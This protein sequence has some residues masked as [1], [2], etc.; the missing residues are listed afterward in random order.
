MID[1]DKSKRPNVT[2]GVIILKDGKFL[3]GKR[4]NAVGAG[5]W[6]LPGGKLE[7]GE[8][9]IDCARREVLEEVGIMI[10]DIRPGSYTNDYFEKE[11]IHFVSIV[12]VAE[13]ESGTVTVIEP[14]K[15][16]EWRWCEWDDMPQPLFLPMQNLVEQGFCPFKV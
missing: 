3:L 2:V 14:D 5:T 10:N 6:G 7:F 9:I 13:Y 8:D 16:S 4:L 11:N 12:V 1:K 15:C